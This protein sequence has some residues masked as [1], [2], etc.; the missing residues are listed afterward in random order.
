MSEG[1]EADPRLYKFANKQAGAM[2]PKSSPKRWWDPE[3]KLRIRAQ[4]PAIFH[5]RSIVEELNGSILDKEWFQSV[6]GL[7][8]MRLMSHL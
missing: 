4:Y 5:V 2:G 7:E 8:L 1:V 6:R 3:N